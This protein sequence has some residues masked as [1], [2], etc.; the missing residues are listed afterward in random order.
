MNNRYASAQAICRD[1]AR[2]IKP[3]RRLK[4]SEGVAQ[5]VHVKRDT[6]NWDLWDATETPYMIEPLDECTNRRYR[7]IIFAGPARTGKSQALVDGLI[8]YDIKVDP[9]DFLLVHITETKGAEHSKKR[10]GPMLEN[11]PALRECLSHRASDN[12][13]H[14]K[15]FKAGNYLKIGHPAKSIF[16]ASEYK[17]VVITDYD[18]N[19]NMLDVGGEGEGFILGLKRTQTYGSR[20]ICVAESSPGYELDPEY[21]EWKVPEDFPHEAPPTKGILSLYNLGDRRQLYWPCPSCKEF[22]PARFEFLRWNKEL[23]DITHQAESVT[24]FCPHCGDSEIAPAKKNQMVAA[25][26]WVPEGMSISKTGEL[27]GTCRNTDIASFWMEGPAATFQ[28]WQNLVYMYLLGEEDYKRT[29]NQGKLKTTVNTDQGRPYKFRRDESKRSVEELTERAEAEYEKL[30]VPEGVRFLVA[31]VDVQAGKNRRFVVQVHGFGVDLQEWLID[32]YNIKD[33]DRMDDE[34]K[35]LKI[36]PGAY[37][38]DW[39]VLLNRVIN[40]SYELAD[41]SG[42]R[43]PILMTAIDTGGEDGVTDNA[44]KFYRRLRQQGLHKRVLL[45]KGASTMAAPLMRE[46]FPDNTKRKDRRTS[47]RGDVPLWLLNTHLFKDQVNNNLER[48]EPGPGFVNF[49]AWLKKAGDWFFR[50]LTAESRNASGKWEKPRGVNNEAFDLFVYSRLCLRILKAHT[51]N[52]QSDALPLW[53]NPIETNPTVLQH[54][55]DVMPTQITRRRRR[56]ARS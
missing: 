42:R 24:C 25:S 3:P 43:L 45:V 11:S 2:L 27:T 48:S 33:A 9:S 44:Y 13:I 32:R 14:D 53:A 23:K 17:R 56:R 12:N 1:T 15:I 4:V 35:P 7:G 18:R 38:E 46:T 29:G 21:D 6:G 50:E 41:G 16:A 37:A 19:A 52:W 28:T 31:S 20:G 36:H 47:S 55:G 30:M 26:R 49:P 34:G 10:I 51:I 39:D 8:G 40:R 54:D 5:F 22:F